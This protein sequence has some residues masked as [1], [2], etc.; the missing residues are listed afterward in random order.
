MKDH[1]SHLALCVTSNIEQDKTQTHLTI[2]D[3]SG[4][5]KN[6]KPLSIMGKMINT[7]PELEITAIIEIEIDNG[8]KTVNVY[9][10]HNHVYGNGQPY[11]LQ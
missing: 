2:S 11:N 3:I 1:L 9:I 10:V 7:R 8:S 4:P 6:H 5:V